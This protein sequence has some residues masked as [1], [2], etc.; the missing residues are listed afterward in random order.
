MRTTTLATLCLPL[1]HGLQVAPTGAPRA[2]CRPHTSRAGRVRL[3]DGGFFGAL[4]GLMGD[5]PAAQEAA[6]KAVP[7]EAAQSDFMF[8]LLVTGGSALIIFPL[9]V[10]AANTAVS[11]F[12]KTGTDPAEEAKLRSES[13]EFELEIL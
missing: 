6:M 9:L 8:P 2:V 3:E 13:T 5:A 11:V 1:A 4:D 10:F 12:A 7:E